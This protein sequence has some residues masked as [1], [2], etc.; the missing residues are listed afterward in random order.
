MWR[1]SSE[2]S[3]D[4][5]YS[6]DSENDI[7]KY[8]QKQYNRFGWARY[9]G[10]VT[11]NE[12]NDLQSKMH[13]KNK[14]KRRTSY[15]ES[16]YEINNTPETGEGVNNV[17]AFT[18]GKADNFT[19]ERVVRIYAY[20]EDIVE[21]FR[22]DIYE[23]TG[24]RALENFARAMGY[25]LVRYYDRKNSQSYGEYVVEKRSQRSGSE[26]EGNTPANGIG[27]QRN[28]SLEQTQSN[29]I[30]PTKVSST[31]DAFF[32]AKNTK[33][34]LS[35]MANTFF[36]DENMSAKDFSGRDYKQT[37]G[38]KVVINVKI[39]RIS[40]TLFIGYLVFLHAEDTAFH[41]EIT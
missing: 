3:G 11:F 19:V 35:S 5:K 18:K 8:S 6:A 34:S 30:A 16:I 37:Q 29:E 25:D 36:G 26:S 33:Y 7:D 24:Y 14:K 12:L 41:Y 4:T 22:K 20:D 28:G 27:H 32:D 9:T 15:G 21:T 31:D 38:Y 40:M 23:N 10:A 39:L 13:I 17:I 1:E 2:T